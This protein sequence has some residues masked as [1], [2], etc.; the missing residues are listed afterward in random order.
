MSLQVGITLAEERRLVAAL[1]GRIG[2]AAQGGLLARA[3]EAAFEL[4]AERVVAD[5]DE[6]VLRLERGPDEDPAVLRM[7]GAASIGETY[8]YRDRPQLDL[9][10]EWVVAELLPAK[11]A[12]GSVVLRAWSAACSTG[13]EA[14]TLLDLLTAVASGFRVQVLGTDMNEAAV[15]GARRGIYRPRSF[16]QAPPQTLAGMLRPHPAGQQIAEAFRRRIRFEALN[17]V[18][19]AVPDPKRGLAAMD[20]VLCRNVLIYL[21]PDQLPRVMQK[22]SVACAPGAVLVLTPAEYS[23]ARHLVG[24]RELGRGLFS[25]QTVAEESSDGPRAVRLPRSEAATP[26][27]PKPFPPRASSSPPPL[28]I[29]GGV[30]LKQT[31]ERLLVRGQDAA[32]QGELAQALS[33]IDQALAL[34]PDWALAHLWSA[35]IHAAGGELEAA[36]NGFERALFLDRRLPAAELGLGQVLTR[37]GRLG[38]ARRHLRRAAAL[39]RSEVDDTMVEGLGV[40]VSVVRR[41]VEDAL[42]ATESDP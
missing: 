23:A 27:V 41:V 12:R 18:K 29:A 22:L 38:D 42:R 10:A 1:E 20:V 21:H 35:N 5:L 39:L 6:L 14:Y 32:D 34:R 13:E 26:E 8:F 25:K 30:D 4:I 37:L 16:R 33:W 7:I 24:F 36:R 3:R 2:I 31:A 17:L 15:A 28:A 40:E 9:L 19:D 11:R